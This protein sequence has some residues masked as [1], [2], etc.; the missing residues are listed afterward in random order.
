[1][2]SRSPGQEKHGPVSLAEK[3]P[4]ADIRMEIVWS[5]TSR[6]YRVVGV[7]SSNFKHFT[8]ERPNDTQPRCHVRLKSGFELGVSG[9]GENRDRSNLQKE[10][11]NM[12]TKARIEKAYPTQKVRH[13]RERT[14]HWRQ[15]QV[16]NED[17]VMFIDNI[18]HRIRYLILQFAEQQ[19][20]KLRCWRRRQ[21]GDF[22]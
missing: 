14:K 2:C 1:M 18:R 21:L 5:S 15:L 11:L 16:C 10:G 4:I 3:S 22:Q 17:F 8:S 20:I 13:D 7:E 12:K 19:I 6:S 9:A